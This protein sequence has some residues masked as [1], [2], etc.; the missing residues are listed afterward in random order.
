MAEEF[1]ISD[2]LKKAK[3]DPKE[4][5]QP[6]VIVLALAFIGYKFLYAPKVIEL[7]KEIKKK[8]RIEADIKTV[9]SAI[10]NLEDIKLDIE[11]RKSKWS[12]AQQLCYRKADM[13]AFL[14]RVREL[15]QKAGINVKTVNPQVISPLQVGK[16]SIENFPVSFF[17]TG[18]LVQMGIFMRLVEMEDKI[19]FISI[20]PLTPNASGVFEVELA[21]TT[22]LIPENL[23]VAP[24]DEQ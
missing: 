17:Y 16:I 13:T 4:A 5:A 10:E 22:L 18:D 2:W 20:P 19:T 15:A 24:P 6:L 21:P 12:K 23:Q 3:S 14:R 9:E 11:E 1:S 7:T 8:Q